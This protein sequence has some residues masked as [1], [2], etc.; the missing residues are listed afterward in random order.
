M[1]KYHVRFFKRLLSSDGRLFKCL[2][3]QIVLS[4]VES[5][6]QAAECASQLFAEHHRTREWR[7]YAD[8]MEVSVATRVSSPGTAQLQNSHLFV[9]ERPCTFSL[10]PQ[11]QGVTH[12]SKLFGPAVRCKRFPR[13]R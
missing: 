12:S 8:E 2:Q 5:R 6:T 1:P 10:R 13:F 9:G 3:E 11:V 4:D 7:L